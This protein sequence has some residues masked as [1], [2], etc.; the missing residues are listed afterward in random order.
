MLISAVNILV[1]GTIEELAHI[2]P[3][4]HLPIY[5]SL[6]KY[7]FIFFLFYIVFFTIFRSWH[8]VPLPS[9]SEMNV[10]PHKWIT[11]AAYMEIFLVYFK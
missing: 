4:S 5:Q 10:P 2:I 8:V 7:G 11:F 3:I 9:A 6:Y 1:N